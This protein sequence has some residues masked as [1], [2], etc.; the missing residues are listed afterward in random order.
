MK[1]QPMRPGVP[2]AKLFPKATP[3]AIDLLQRMLVFDPAKRVS[4]EEALEHPYLAS[5][6]NLEDEP[7]ADSSFSFDFEKEDLTE[8]RLKELIFEYVLVWRCTCHHS[9]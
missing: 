4:V 8:A 6:H 5:L 3:E 1:N 9:G 2:F 7:V